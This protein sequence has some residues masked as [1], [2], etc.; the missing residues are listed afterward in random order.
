MSNIHSSV[1]PCSHVVIHLHNVW[2]T[3]NVSSQ[4][5]HVIHATANP[6][7]PCRPKLR[8]RS[9]Q[10]CKPQKKINQ[11][12]N[13]IYFPVLFLIILYLQK[14]NQ[15]FS[16]QYIGQPYPHYSSL[17]HKGPVCWMC[18]LTGTFLTVSY[19]VLWRMDSGNCSVRVVMEQTWKPKKPL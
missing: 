15:N 2:S 16:F 9:Q 1:N 5:I 10:F 18:F 8:D 13:F 14:M 12:N 6:L 11:L 17:Y 3:N 4:S 7:E 19:M